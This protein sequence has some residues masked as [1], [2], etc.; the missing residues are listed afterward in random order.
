[1]NPTYDS[2]IPVSRKR[3]RRALLCVAHGVCANQFRALL[4]ELRQRR[5]RQQAAYKH[6]SGHKPKGWVPEFHMS[7]PYLDYG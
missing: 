7:P 5:P 6:D 2:G 1:M 4:R 3:D